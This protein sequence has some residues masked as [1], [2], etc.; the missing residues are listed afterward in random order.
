MLVELQ[1]DNPDGR[2]KSGA[3][4]QVAFKL[5]AAA[6]TTKVASTALLFKQAGP[7]VAVV[8]PDGHVKVRPVTIVRD[9]GLEVEIGAGLSPAS[10]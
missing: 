1:I 3:Y 2:L 9:L 8:G 4:A 10:A 6:T 7:T 5:P